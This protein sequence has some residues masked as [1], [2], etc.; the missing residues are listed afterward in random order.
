V[1]DIITQKS[2]SEDSSI[3]YN[4]HR[5]ESYWQEQWRKDGL[6]K[7]VEPIKNQRTFYALSMFPYPSGT[8]H[9]GHVRN[10][11]I[12]DVIARFQRMLGASVLHP[13]GWDSFGLPAENAAIERS[14]DPDTWTKKN[15]AQMR[16]QLNRLGLSVDWD[17]EI[18]TSS[19]EY[20]KWTQYL[21]IELFK[22]GLAYQKKAT[23]NWD[24]IDQTVLANEQVDSEG[25]SWRSGAVVEKRKLNQWFLAITN[26]AEELNNDLDNLKGW[27][28]KV[29]T[30]QANWIGKSKG[31]KI[32]FKL[33]SNKSKYIDIFTTRVDT[34]L[35]VTYVV[36][37]PNHPLT[38]EIVLKPLKGKLDDF[39]LEFNK[40][41]DKERNSDNRIKKGLNLGD[42]A[43]NP[44]NGE[45]VEIWTADYVLA[46]YGTGAV[47][48]V[49]AHDERDFKFAKQYN[50]P[51]KYVIKD[52]LNN[53]NKSIP[54][55]KD[56]ILFNSKEF[57]GLK[58]ITAR[59][60]IT[61]KGVNE[62]WAKE[63][64][65]Y[66]LRDWLISRQRYWGCPIPII[67]CKYCGQIAVPEKDLP[68]QLPVGIKLT[69]KGKSPLLETSEWINVECPV[70]KKLAQRET[71]TIDTFICSSWYYLR[72]VDAHNY[73]KPFDKNIVNKWLP[74]NQYVGG[75]E[76]A[77]LHLLYSRF[78]TKALKTRNLLDINEPF[79]NLLTQG[80]VQGLT[81]KNPITNKYIP[82]NEIKNS[83]DPRDPL[84][85]DKLDIFYEKMS[86]SKYNGI[87][88]SIVIEKYGADT[89]RMFI[90]FKAPP[91][92]DLEWEDSDVEGQYRFIQRIYKITN[93]FINDLQNESSRFKNIKQIINIKDLSENE[94]NLWIA[95]NKA[96]KN[97]TEDLER[98]KFNTAISELMILTNKISDNKYKNNIDLLYSAFINL[99]KLLSPF[100]PHLSEELWNKL[101]NNTSIHELSWPI[102]D[103][104]ILVKQTYEL[105]IQIN[106]KV[107]GRVNVD[108]K[109]NSKEI[110]ELCLN[111]DIAKKWCKKD[112]PKRIILV[113]GK[114]INIV[115]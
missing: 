99:I 98:N 22:E 73:N 50:L 31:T 62:N 11:V 89:A 104:S 109:L 79:K 59:E 100:A 32:R 58:S 34:L 27:P 42:Y 80:M 64:T 83:E 4:H 24:P 115:I 57:D 38:S 3:R 69:G 106:G 44:L 60:K 93:E 49:P 110:E 23:V 10:Y 9:M 52:G 20:Y 77:I 35:G 81:Y 61:K 76:H 45:K 14:I 103:P 13:M 53:I 8:L 95:V 54:F 7:T 36:I 92:K 12:T 86:K 18:T 111:T 82:N 48:G 91:E 39:L 94:M 87:D 33:L 70:C 63:I 41:N 114:L 108:N 74:V 96:I 15:I 85:N 43:I 67:N 56:G 72:Y 17:R 84:S 5:I 26:Y 55:T 78:I 1:K 107:R 19:K 88:P 66:K 105:V 97:M 90:L 71:D 29:K 40:L 46:E 113:K 30:M 65:K 6:Y 2:A 112:K 51:I 37:A 16:D 102:Y 101:G 68:V 25:R 28:G 21:F 75:I 47:M